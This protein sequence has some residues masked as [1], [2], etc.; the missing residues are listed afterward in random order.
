MQV[1]KTPWRALPD[2]LA[3]ATRR[4]LDL[5]ALAQVIYRAV[6]R[7]VAYD[8]ACF[9]VT[10]PASG[11]VAW[12]SKTRSLGVGDEEFAAVENGPPDINGFA[13]IAQRKPP[14]GVL[15]IDTGG[16]PE[17]CRRH[18]DL[19]LP[20]FGFTDELRVVFPS[21]GVSWGEMALYRAH[22]DPPF[23]I[24]DAGQLAGITGLVGAAI[25]RSLFRAPPAPGAVPVT[26]QAVLIIDATDQL[27]HLTASAQAAIEELGGWECGSLPA[28]LL[29]IVA[30]TRTR[31]A[32]SVTLVKTSAGRWLSLRAATLSGP[33]SGGGVV[34]TIDVTP[35]TALS[36]LTMTAHGL[37][38]REEEV[39][40]LILHGASTESIASTLHLSPHTVQDHLKKIF[41]KLG[42]TSR[43]DMIARLA[44]D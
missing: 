35:R 1:E 11:L 9:A 16:H 29:A 13:E 24:A 20:R 2:L 26:G 41:G 23:T 25:A 10:D 30:S 19:M 40:L 39:A 21:R 12:A 31:S 15:S 6:A 17:R 34:V 5:P 14:V 38:A 42:V 8:F 3:D 44:L 4:D 36:R 32:Q 18:R 22:D 27:T 28:N 37:S 33:A 43:R 7:Y